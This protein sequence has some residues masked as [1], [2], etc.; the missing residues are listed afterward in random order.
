[1]HLPTSEQG[2]VVEVHFRPSS[3]NFNPLTNRRLQAWLEKE[4]KDTTRVDQGFNVPSVR[5]ALV[6]QLAHVQRHFLAGGIGL[7]HICDYY[8]LL[9][10]ASEADRR[11]V[12]EV[13]KPFGLRHTAEAMMWVP[14]EVLCLEERLMYFRKDRYRGEWMLREIMAGGNFGKFADSG[15]RGLLSRVMAGRLRHLKLMRFDFWESLWVE[16]RFWKAVVKTIPLRIKY[17]TLS[18]RNVAR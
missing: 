5:F 2:V 15:R 8:W 1:M 14:G 11:A 6:M 12:A 3:G 10:N 17:R 7:R 13:M 9:K 18:L 4:I 16:L